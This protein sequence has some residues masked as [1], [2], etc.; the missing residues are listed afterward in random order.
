MARKPDYHPNYERHFG[1]EARRADVL[2]NLHGSYNSWLN[3]PTISDSAE[4]KARTTFLTSPTG[5]VQDFLDQRSER[6]SQLISEKKY[7]EAIELVDQ[8]LEEAKT[9]FEGDDQI[10][11]RASSLIIR[12][13]AK[14]RLATF[15]DDE[16]FSSRR[17]RQQAARLFAFTSAAKSRFG[18]KCNKAKRS[19]TGMYYM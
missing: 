2:D 18:E 19:S 8:Q 7:Y 10:I 17:S 14:E 16:L 5:R 6:F 12:G 4:I 1:S 11:A 13:K 3:L 15:G 9:S